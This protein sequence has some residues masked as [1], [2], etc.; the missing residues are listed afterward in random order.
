MT[1]AITSIKCSNRP[2]IKICLFASFLAHS[3]V[4]RSS[5]SHSCVI[6]LCSFFTFFSSRFGAWNE[7]G[8]K[9]ISWRFDSGCWHSSSDRGQGKSP[10]PLRKRIQ[11]G[12]WVSNLCGNKKGNDKKTTLLV[13]N[14]Y[15]W[16]NCIVFCYDEIMIVPSS[17]LP[18]GE[19]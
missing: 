17:L 4:F 19:N 12:A 10:I 14:M 13:Y 6:F 8:A 5:K 3:H 11:R 7:R 15:I 1:T 18:L 9:R 2:N 16:N